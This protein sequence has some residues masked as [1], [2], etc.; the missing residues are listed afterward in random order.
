MHAVTSKNGR[1]FY[2]SSGTEDNDTSEEE[3]E[4][5]TQEEAKQTPVIPRDFPSYS[6]TLCSTG[7]SACCVISFDS[8]SVD[9]LAEL[10]KLKTG[11]PVLEKEIPINA[12]SKYE[13]R[14][15]AENEK[16]QEEEQTEE[17]DFE[18]YSPDSTNT[19]FCL[20]LSN[21]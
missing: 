21:T 9:S 2:S 15:R 10:A 16:I 6:T 13:I 1:G 4:D 20:T 3:D 12:Y 11:A 8:P 18:W 17:E 19:Y 5:E 14:N 7:K